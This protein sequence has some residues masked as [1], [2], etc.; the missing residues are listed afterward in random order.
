MDENLLIQKVS[1][2]L[3]ITENE[4]KYD[5]PLVRTIDKLVRKYEEMAEEKGVTLYER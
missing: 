3:N 5:M 1:W 2:I 4:V